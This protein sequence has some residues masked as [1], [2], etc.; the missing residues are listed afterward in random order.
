MNLIYFAL[1]LLYNQISFKIFNHDTDGISRVR[2]TGRNQSALIQIGRSGFAAKNKKV[3]IFLKWI[4]WMH[5]KLL[6]PYK[7]SMEFR[8]SKI[9]W[10]NFLYFINTLYLIYWDTYFI[11]KKEFWMIIILYKN[12][13]FLVIILQKVSFWYLITILSLNWKFN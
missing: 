13:L 2:E 5:S 9:I 11:L 1:K 6:I 7:K 3:L 10:E 4:N 12:C 8:I